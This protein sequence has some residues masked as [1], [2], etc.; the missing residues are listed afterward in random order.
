MVDVCGLLMVSFRRGLFSV[1]SAKQTGRIVR[2]KRSR[3]QRD[4]FEVHF[5]LSV[6]L[7]LKPA[8]RTP[9]IRDFFECPLQTLV[10]RLNVNPKNR[11]TFA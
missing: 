9:H 7:R 8:A 4:R 6:A 5:W 11:V 10:H 3:K 2:G 1:P